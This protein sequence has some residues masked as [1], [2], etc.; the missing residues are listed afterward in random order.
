MFLEGFAG[1]LAVEFLEHLLDGFDAVELCFLENGDA[2][3]V[4]VGKE[5]AVIQ[6]RQTAAF[7]GENRG[8]GGADHGVAHAH[9]VNA[10]DVLANVG[11]DALEVVEN[12]FF[13]VSPIF[14]EEKLAVLR[15]RAFGEGPVKGPDGVVD[16]SAEA[17]VHGIDVAQRR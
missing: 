8:D 6:T 5:D 12:G 4:G 16:V 11:V 10:G 3:E 17:L 15:G 2:A 13:P 9:D 1:G 14:I 7:F